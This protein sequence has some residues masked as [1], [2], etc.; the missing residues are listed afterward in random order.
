MNTLHSRFVVLANENVD[1]DQIIPAR[2]L[3]ATTRDGIGAGLFAD[4]RY[5]DVGAPRPDFVLNQPEAESAEVLVVGR[6]FGCGS[7]R[8][9]AAWALMQNGIRVV[10]GT[11]IADIFR[12]NA[13]MNG[14]LPII[15]SEDVQAQLVEAGTGTVEVDVEAQTVRF[16]DDAEHFFD[17]DPFAKYCLLNGVD[18][19]GFLL[20]QVDAID[21]YEQRA[22]LVVGDL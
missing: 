19:F 14:V 10:V 6:N 12:A 22:A 20:Q 9:H 3:T 2:F 21:N 17:V 4:W 11:E 7:S 15:I 5:D 16:D 8:E 1:T 13:L 18:E